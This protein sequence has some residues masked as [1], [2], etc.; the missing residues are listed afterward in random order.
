MT[1]NYASNRVNGYKHVVTTQV[2]GDEIPSALLEIIAKFEIAGRTYTQTLAAQANQNVEFIW[3]GLDS[4]GKKVE[5]TTTGKLSIGYKYEAYYLKP[6]SAKKSFGQYSNDFTD[7]KAN[8]IIKW[9]TEIVTLNNTVQKQEIANG[10]SLSK[11]H[12]YSNGITLKGDGTSLSKKIEL[13]KG[14]LSY[15]RFEENAKDSSG[16]GHNGIEEGNITYIDG[17]IGKA[18]KFDGKTTLVR[19]P[20]L[21]FTKEF[22]IG[23]W[24]KVDEL[25]NYSSTYENTIF[26]NTKSNSESRFAM[27]FNTDNKIHG[28]IRKNDSGNNGLHIYNTNTIDF[29]KWYHIFFRKE[30]SKYQIYI[31]GVLDAEETAT[32]ELLQDATFMGLGDD[33]P[34]TNNTKFNGSL[35]EFRIYNRA[36]SQDEISDLYH[37]NKINSS[38]NSLIAKDNS[39]SYTFDIDGKHLKTLD[40]Q[41]DK[42][43]TTF[44]YDSNDRLIAIKDR[45]DNTTTIERDTNG[46]VTA[47]KAPNGQV[48]KLAIDG[49]GNL[50]TVTYEDSSNYQF[51]YNNGNLM[52]SEI[53]PKGNIFTHEFNANGRVTKVADEEG[54]WKNY[55]KNG[56]NYV[57]ET[58]L[59]SSRDIVMDGINKQTTSASGQKSIVLYT[60]NGMTKT[61]QSCGIE[62]LTHYTLDQKTGDE[63]IK[64]QTLKLPSGKKLTTSIERVYAFNDD[65]TTKTLSINSSSNGNTAVVNTDY[66]QGL[67]TTTSATG[68]I[69]KSYFDTNT[70]LPSKQEIA[71]LHPTSYSFDNKGQ[72]IATKTADRQQQISYDSRGNIASLTDEQGKVTRFSYDPVDR[73]LKTTT[74][75]GADLQYQYDQNGNLTVFSTPTASDHQFTFNRVN[76]TSALGSETINYSYDGSL[77][78]GISYA[79]ILNQ[80][81]SLDYD[82]DLRISQL[83]YANGN[84]ALTYDKDGLLTNRG[85]FTIDRNADNGLAMNVRDWATI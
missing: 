63:V 44:E 49:N 76:K 30:D 3:D 31:N 82:K 5:G 20:P 46:I 57:I 13:E 22:T 75:S 41:T 42:V 61:V 11:H 1:L 47:I 19:T 68:R 8:P 72:L 21:F 17:Q 28:F 80:N 9:K 79:G 7:V 27:W 4:D 65:K 71:G 66:T 54:G 2:S 55:N 16:N 35:D 59:G 69:T 29:N 26:E 18:I 83:S 33:V 32:F 40:T 77:L 48:T 6:P 62:S 53:E 70:L 37:S 43:L 34:N 51:A 50:T 14:L 84:Q 64:D 73:L 56:N 12:M 23:Y 36:L 52:T 67:T 58:A 25:V 45:F 15:W 78:T 85:K 60:D 74:P 81:I 39:L 24:L 10:W 38:K